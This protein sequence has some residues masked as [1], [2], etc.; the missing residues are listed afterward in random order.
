MAIKKMRNNSINLTYAEGLLLL[1]QTMS[2]YALHQQ[3]NVLTNQN[4]IITNLSSDIKSLNMQLI[5]IKSQN[6]MQVSAKMGSVM[7]TS[8]I[9]SFIDPRLVLGLIGT[10]VLYFYVVPSLSAKLALFPA[11]LKSLLVPVKFALLSLVPFTKEVK[12]I[13][14]IKDG[15]TFRLELLG[16]LVSA[17]EAR[18]A[19]SDTFKPVED[20]IKQSGSPSEGLPSSSVPTVPV[21]PSPPVPTI[22]DIPSLPIPTVP[23]IPASMDVQTVSDMITVVD[24]TDQTLNMLST[25]G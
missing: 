16:D 9:P 7:P 11:S 13:E 2:A 1:S 22:P 18:Q 14:F 21:I 17:L 10:G 5:E 4:N 25:L 6:S 19:D 8:A 3:H 23:N 20:L 12:I 24:T 15:C